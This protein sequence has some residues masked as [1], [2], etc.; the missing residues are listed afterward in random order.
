MRYIKRDM[1]AL[2]VQTAYEYPAILV[3]G[4][5]QVGKTTMLEHIIEQH[6][7]PHE[8]VTLDDLSSRSLAKNDPAMFFQLHRPPVLID[9]VQYAPELFV[10]M[11]KMIDAGAEPGSFWLT[12]SQ[13][14]RLM[15]LSGES[16]AGRIAV[17]RFRRSLNMSCMARG[18]T[19]PFPYRWRPCGIVRIGLPRQTRKKCLRACTKGRCRQ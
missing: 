1:E 13:Q 9:E 6:D 4:P 17:R 12:G 7:L 15:E 19:S 16:L 11:K 18:P 8:K 3:T 10:E 14:F 5:R 2:V